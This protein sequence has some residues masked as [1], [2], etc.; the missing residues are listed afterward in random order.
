MKRMFLGALLAVMALAAHAD[1]SSHFLLRGN[2]SLAGITQG[3]DNSDPAR[4]YYTPDGAWAALNAEQI[5]QARQR[6]LAAVREQIYEAIGIADYI[7]RG[8]FFIG[9]LKTSWHLNATL[10]HSVAFSIEARW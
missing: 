7:P 9:N 1:D 6:Q 2:P 5:D 8:E 3:N 10:Q 4:S